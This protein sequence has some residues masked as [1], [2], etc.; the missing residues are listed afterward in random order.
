MLVNFR[1]IMSRRW[2]KEKTSDQIRQMARRALGVLCIFCMPVPFFGFF[3]MVLGAWLLA[4]DVAGLLSRPFGQLFWSNRQGKRVPIY[5]KAEALTLRGNLHE[6]E[7]A[8]EKIIR[9]FP[10]ELKAHTELLRIA[11]VEIG[12]L[13]RANERF[14]KSMKSLKNESARNQ[15]LQ[16]YQSYL[17]NT[18]RHVRV[19]PKT[20]GDQ[21]IT[22]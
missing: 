5:S 16:I 7:Q 9:E 10:Q 20:Q 22:Q 3:I 13:N 18:G 8:Y 11:M 19:F 2:V 12:D 17:K 4:P 14:L 15:L 21:T 1:K 6:A